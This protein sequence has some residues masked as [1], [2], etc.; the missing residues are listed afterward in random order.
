MCARIS[1]GRF[2]CS[3]TLAIVKVL[4]DPVTPSSTWCCSPAGKPLHNLVDRPRL[5]APRLV[6]GHE[7]KVHGEIIREKRIYGE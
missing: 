2:D 6:T 1:A 5:I 7:L 4:P 3:M